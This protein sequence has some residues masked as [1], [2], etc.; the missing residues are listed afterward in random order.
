MTDVKTLKKGIYSFRE[1][2]INEL[3]HITEFV[4]KNYANSSVRT[5]MHYSQKYILKSLLIDESLPSEIKAIQHKLCFGIINQ[6]ENEIEAIVIGRP[7]RIALR[8]EMIISVIVSLLCT[9][10]T[11]RHLFLGPKLIHELQER[12]DQTNLLKY[13]L[14]AGI[15]LPYPQVKI[16]TERI[17]FICSDIQHYNNW[18]LKTNKNFLVSGIQLEKLNK[19]NAIKA[20]QLW[21]LFNSDKDCYQVFNSENYYFNQFRNTESTFSYIGADENGETVFWFSIDKTRYYYEDEDKYHEVANVSMFAFSKITSRQLIEIIVMKAVELNFDL[22]VFPQN[23]PMSYETE[24]E[25][26]VLNGSEQWI[27][28]YYSDV[29]K[30]INQFHINFY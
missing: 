14:F 27:Y 24:T 13:T 3:P 8:G 29:F 30:H 21:N 4:S 22:I 1:F 7:T 2:G 19:C 11:K 6:K 9:K 23:I 10:R 16:A 12:L 28:S 5:V 18:Y 15:H 17:V 26:R 20:I 25:L